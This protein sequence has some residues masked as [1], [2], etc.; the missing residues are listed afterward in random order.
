MKIKILIALLFLSSICEAKKHIIFLHNKFLETHTVNDSHPEYGKVELNQIKTKFENAGFNVIINQ[1]TDS[2]TFDS[3]INKVITQVDSIITI[4]NNDSITVIGTSKGG[5][6]AQWVSSRLKNPKINY[7]FIGCYRDSDLKD[8]PDINYCG[9][10]LSIYETSDSYGVSAIDKIKDSKLTIPNFKEVKLSTGL[11]HGFLFKAL[12][13]W[14]IPCINW[15]NCN[16]K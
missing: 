7:V 4:N 11:K 8:H 9:N 12:D 16:Y 1:R 2:I 15:A 3:A 14:M 13:E 10:I 5:Y 6:I